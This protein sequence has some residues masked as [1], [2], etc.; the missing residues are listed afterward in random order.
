MAN[1]EGADVA[2]DMYYLFERCMIEEAEGMEMDKL[3][4]GF[5]QLCRDAMKVRLLMRSSPEGYSCVALREGLPLSRHEEIAEPYAVFRGKSNE[6]REDIRFTLFGALVKHA[7]YKGEGEVV[8][9]KAE[10][11]MNRRDQESW[12]DSQ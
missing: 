2:E 8:L 5:L 1:D 12:L 9:Q 4:Q 3:R 10:V 7:K 11:V 6:A